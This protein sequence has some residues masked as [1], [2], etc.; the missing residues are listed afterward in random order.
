MGFLYAYI[1]SFWFVLTIVTAAAALAVYLYRLAAKMLIFDIEYSRKF[2]VKALYAGEKVTLIETIYN[3]TSVPLFFAGVD[4][5]I[6][7]DLKLTEYEEIPKETMQYFYSEFRVIMPHMKIK[8]RHEIYC[9]KRGNYTLESVDIYLAGSVRHI[10]SKASL[11]VYPQPLAAPRSDMNGSR[12][13]GDER[14]LLPLISDPF[15]RSGLRE[16]LPGDPMNMINFKASARTGGFMNGKLLVNKYDW[17]SG[18]TVMV[19]LNLRQSLYTD[20]LDA[21]QT[22]Y[23]REKKA[24]SGVQF[25]RMT[26]YALSQSCKLLLSAVRGGYRAGFAANCACGDSRSYARFE[27]STG[28]HY[29]QGV[30]SFMAGMEISAGASFPKM[31]GDDV[32][33]GLSGAEIYVFTAYGDPETEKNIRLLKQAGNSVKVIRM[34]PDAVEEQRAV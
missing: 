5:F 22:V 8:R 19:Y 31:L 3:P 17:C 12:V 4:G 26:E 27:P 29:L 7:S 23:Q 33:R 9:R 14:A 28:D 20:T 11:C 18:R 1:H 6:T 32:E 15:S 13:L 21:S 16:Y 10:E 25:E 2:S 30:L 34:T 24:I